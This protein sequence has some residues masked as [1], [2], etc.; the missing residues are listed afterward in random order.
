MLSRV[1]LRG[2]LGIIAQGGRAVPLKQVAD[3]EIV[4]QPSRIKRRD[5]LW[6]VTVRA[7]LVPELTA[8]EVIGD[9]QPWLNDQQSAWGR[10]GE[11]I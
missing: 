6:T 9:L 11:L 7:D 1:C 2:G 8:A 10:S 3:L 5:R 4:W